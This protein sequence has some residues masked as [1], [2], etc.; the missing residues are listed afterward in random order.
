MLSL[1]NRFLR[2]RHILAVESDR[3]GKTQTSGQVGK[4]PGYLTDQVGECGVASVCKND[5]VSM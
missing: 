1:S 5:F 3:K 2:C 4:D